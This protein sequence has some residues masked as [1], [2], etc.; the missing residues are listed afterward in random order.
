MIVLD[1]PR[2]TLIARFY[3]HGIVRSIYLS[4]SD[5]SGIHV[6]T[7]EYDELMETCENRFHKIAFNSVV[8]RNFDHKDVKNITAICLDHRDQDS[9]FVAHNG[10]KII[11]RLNMV[12]DD[13]NI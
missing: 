4:N 13:D 7:K 8:Y 1:L 12:Q 6:L 9:I 3:F 5:H 11:S 2:K 10:G